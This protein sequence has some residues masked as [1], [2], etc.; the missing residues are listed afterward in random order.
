MFAVNSKA[1]KILHIFLVYPSHW[2]LLWYYIIGIPGSV[3]AEDYH[4]FVF[5]LWCNLYSC[6]NIELSLCWG[7]V[8]G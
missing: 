7:F 2:A 8:R 5:C 6:N 3:N 1:G 4:L